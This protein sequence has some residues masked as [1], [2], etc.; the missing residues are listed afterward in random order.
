MHGLPDGKPCTK[1]DKAGIQAFNL[2]KRLQLIYFVKIS[3]LGI[4]FWAYL[5]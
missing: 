2:T 3:S 5:A 4:Y 1:I